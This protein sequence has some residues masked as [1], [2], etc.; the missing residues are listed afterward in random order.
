LANGKGNIPACTGSKGLRFLI[1]SAVEPDQ[2]LGIT[3]RQIEF[4]DR[5]L[6]ERLDRLAGILLQIGGHP[7]DGATYIFSIR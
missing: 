2:E 3:G 4:E 5:F 7:S 6:D 1:G